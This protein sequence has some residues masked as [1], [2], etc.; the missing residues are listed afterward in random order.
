MGSPG[1]VLMRD[2]DGQAAMPDI[3]L[4]DLEGNDKKAKFHTGFVNF[5]TMLLIFTTLVK[6]EADKPYDWEGQKRS[7]GASVHHTE[8][9]GKPGRTHKLH[10]D[11]EFLMVMTRLRLGLLEEQTAD[12]FKVYMFTVSRIPTT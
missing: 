10:L 9:V 4:T 6:H 7:L 2:V 1:L 12:I 3:P 5:P 11:S 8:G